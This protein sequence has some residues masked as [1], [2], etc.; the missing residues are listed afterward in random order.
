MYTY[1]SYFLGIRFL[2][3]SISIAND[4]NN[5]TEKAIKPDKN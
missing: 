2:R 3:N 1:W 4:N 5:N